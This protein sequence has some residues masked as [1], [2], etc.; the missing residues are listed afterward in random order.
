MT[1]F[2]IITPLFNKG[3]YIS[4]TI[5]SVRGQKMPDWEMIIIDNGSTDC[6]PSI[7]HQYAQLDSRIHVIEFTNRQGP[8]AARNAGLQI[9][10]GQWVLFLDSDDLI[11]PDYLAHRYKVA[12]NLTKVQIIVG[13]WQEFEDIAPEKRVEKQP[14]Q[15]KGDTSKI[16]ET[17]IAYAPW[18]L[19][20]AIVRRDWL[21][22]ERKWIEQLDQVSSEDTAFWF[23]TVRGAN[24]VWCDDADAL[25]RIHTF[26]SRNMICD[27]AKWIQSV[28]KIIEH[29]LD[30]LKQKQMFPNP[31]QC[32]N[33]FRVFESLYRL[34]LKSE[35]YSESQ[36]L[37]KLVYKFMNMSP[38]NL[39]IITRKVIGLRMF[40]FLRY[41][42]TYK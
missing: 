34:A 23:T 31:T 38:P 32:E 39:G 12:A 35:L 20:A 40:N 15:W 26:N 25:Y 5:S 41:G 8:G 14:T 22:Q 3:N 16:V 17:A 13:K 6:G 24:I 42:I 30:Y 18:A 2:S 4:E 7:A 21:T 29:N 27:P 9:A 19:H 11:E 37:Q 1:Y 28:S 36:E 10:I 33:I